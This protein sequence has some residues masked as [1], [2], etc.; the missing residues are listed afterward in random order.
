M[1]ACEEGPNAS[2]RHLS[3]P[4]AGMADLPTLTTLR[5][6]L[7]T[8]DSLRAD[9]TE[10]TSHP[11]TTPTRAKSHA[12]GQTLWRAGNDEMRFINQVLRNW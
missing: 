10:L 2:Y 7:K 5:G 4:V 6:R 9:A 1:R 8:A 11:C 3:V 12:S